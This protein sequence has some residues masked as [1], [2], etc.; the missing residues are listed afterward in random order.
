MYRDSNC[1]ITNL[2]KAEMWFMISVVSLEMMGLTVVSWNS[3]FNEGCLVHFMVTIRVLLF[4]FR[5][6][7]VF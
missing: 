3:S 5:I 1:R 2:D 7:C 4:G 6:L